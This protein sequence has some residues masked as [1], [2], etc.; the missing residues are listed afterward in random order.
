MAAVIKDVPTNTNYPFEQ[1]VS[2]ST[3]NPSESFGGVSSTTTF[4]QIPSAVN[5]E[6]LRPALNKFNKKY[7]ETAWGEDFVSIDLQPLSNIHFDERFGSNNYSTSQTYLWTLGLIGL[8]MILIACINFVNLATAKAI[9]RS[10]EIGMRK[11]LGSSKKNIIAQFMG[12]SFLLAFTSLFL[13]VTFAQMFFPYFSEITNLNIGN[14]FTYSLD[15]ILFIEGLLFF[16]TLTMGLYPSILLSNFKPL[17]V[18]RQKMAASPIKGLTLRRGLIA[19]QLT[20]SQAMVIGAI[21]IACQLHFFQN[22]DL[23]FDKDSVLV[24][25]LPG[26]VA[27]DRVFTLKNKISQFPFVKNTSLTSTV[28]M[29]GH[30]SSTGLT[31]KDSEIQE[32]FN[33]QYIYADNTYTDVMEFELLAGRASMTEIDQDTVRGFVVNETLIERLAFGTPQEA[34]GKNINVHG[35]ESEIIGVVKDFHTV[36][37]HEEIK[38]IAL[39][40]GTQNYQLLALKYDPQNMQQ[41]I[42]QL[43]SEWSTI[44]PDKNMDFYFQDEQMGDMYNSE[45]PF[46]KNNPCL[47]NHFHHHRLHRP[48]RSVGLFFHKKI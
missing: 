45:I 34:L 43:E 31:S 24:V 30:N 28:P 29:A 13:G 20:T 23:G 33:V 21:V 1:L 9:G 27:M 6:D 11:I 22:K 47:Y 26:G 25:N 38:P 44:F 2:Y 12:E 32:R 17:E 18:V 8:F 48:D 35:F 15:L 16:V 41:S 10:K 5:I 37:L 40:Y 14:E 4:V 19:F 42:P 36:S 46:F 3:I 7:M 39:I